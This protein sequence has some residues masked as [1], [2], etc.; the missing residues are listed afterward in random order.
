MTALVVLALAAGASAQV[1]INKESPAFI[2]GCAFVTPSN[3]TNLRVL[4]VNATRIQVRLSAIDECS[5]IS[6]ARGRLELADCFCA[7]P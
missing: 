6:V 3:V 1:T 4:P 2:E 7:G 5:S